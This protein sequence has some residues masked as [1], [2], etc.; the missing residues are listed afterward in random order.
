MD[1]CGSREEGLYTF[2]LM[3]TRKEEDLF[4]NIPRVAHLDGL[5]VDAEAHHLDFVWLAVFE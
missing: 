3:D 1:L 5:D 2:F 4:L